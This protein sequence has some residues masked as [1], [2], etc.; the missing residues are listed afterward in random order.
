[1]NVFVPEYRRLGVT[2]ASQK[3]LQIA[4][5]LQPCI[6]ERSRCRPPQNVPVALGLLYDYTLLS[7]VIE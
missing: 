1:M 7:I 5:L 2:H 3:E 4:R 6:R